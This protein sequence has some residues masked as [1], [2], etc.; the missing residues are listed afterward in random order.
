MNNLSEAQRIAF[1]SV[2]VNH[3][4]LIY[5]TQ[6]E[7]VIRFMP[8]FV[9]T[10]YSK[11]R[12]SGNLV[13]DRIMIPKGFKNAKWYTNIRPNGNMFNM[14]KR[15]FTNGSLDHLSPPLSNDEIQDAMTE[16]KTMLLEHNIEFELPGDRAN[17]AKLLREGKAGNKY[18][19]LLSILNLTYNLIATEDYDF[20]EIASVKR[21]E[22]DPYS[23]T[24]RKITPHYEKAMAW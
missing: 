14:I 19:D 22:P 16:L 23:I 18:D 9:D 24:I 1:I 17:L 3:L 8:L 11:L 4:R 12:V 10:L 7:G 2:G 6:E 5:C 20:S 21:K 13:S 15:R